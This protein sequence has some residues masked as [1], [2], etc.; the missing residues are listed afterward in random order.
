M[1]VNGLDHINIIANDLDETVAFYE[2]VLGLHGQKTPNTMP[3]FEGRWLNDAGGRA[4]IHLMTH[5]AQRHGERLAAS[6]RATGTIDHIAL[7]CEGFE[8]TKQRCAE[9]GIEH[10]V[11]DRQFADLRQIFV[12]DP[13]DVSLE[14]NFAGD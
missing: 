1:K 14:L 8:A 5:N 4:I 2:T 12:T 7:A 13:N 9:L 10:R 3:G 11:N 6:G